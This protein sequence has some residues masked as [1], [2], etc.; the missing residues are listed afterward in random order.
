MI[1]RPS[2]ILLDGGQKIAKGHASAT[3]SYRKP[4]VRNILANNEIRSPKE[5]RR[6]VLRDG[7]A[8][9]LP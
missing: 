4:G 2:A 5:R 9:M 8:T 1:A 7:S 6:K 3:P